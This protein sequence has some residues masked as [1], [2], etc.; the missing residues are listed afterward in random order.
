MPTDVLVAP[1]KSTF[2]AMG[3][4]MGSAGTSRS[5]PPPARRRI[6]WPLAGFLAGTF[7]IVAAW[8]IALLGAW[9]PSIPGAGFNFH[10]S[11]DARP[12]SAGDPD[13]WPNAGG[14]RPSPELEPWSP[15]HQSIEMQDTQAKLQGHGFTPEYEA[16]IPMPT[17]RILQLWTI[18][19][20]LPPLQGYDRCRAPLRRC[21]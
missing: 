19:N 1:F 10:R 11:G 16:D 20:L 7:L 6:S 13:Q 5:A 9:R 8:S 15:F 14:K 18:A 2:E 3:P 12:A 21:A 17:F 4:T